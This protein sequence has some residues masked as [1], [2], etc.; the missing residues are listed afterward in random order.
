MAQKLDGGV[1][2]ANY[3][4]H[5]ASHQQ[6]TLTLLESFNQQEAE[7]LIEI[8]ELIGGHLPTP[9]TLAK[10]DGQH[11]SQ[12]LGRPVI[13]KQFW[14]GWI[15]YSSIGLCYEAGKLL[16]TLHQIPLPQKMHSRR[17]APASNWRKMTGSW[18]PQLTEWIEQAEKHSLPIL[19]N[20][21][22]VMIHGD[23]FLD[24][25]LEDADRP[26]TLLD[27]ECF[28]YE[29]ASLDI[30]IAILGLCETDG[31]VDAQKVDALMQ[32][33]R[34][35]VEQAELAAAVDWGGATLAYYRYFRQKILQNQNGRS[36]PWQ[37]LKQLT[38]SFKDL[39]DTSTPPGEPAKRYTTQN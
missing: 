2:N 31:R 29:P 36:R 32:G 13:L 17:R 19:E 27:P 10:P 38:E 37:A 25:L 33:Y 22:R 34:N 15:P 23:M 35:P 39:N 24:N 26:L 6:Y 3:I 12:Y 21:P 9:P 30:G 4:I 7:E 20:K 11:Q 5:T 14:P 18:D 8:T 16:H 28:A 1:A